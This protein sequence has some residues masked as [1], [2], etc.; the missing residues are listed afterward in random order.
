[1]QRFRIIHRTYYRFSQ[2]VIL[3]R[4]R[5]RIYP[6]ESSECRVESFSVNLDPSIK[7]RWHRDAEDNSVAVADFVITTQAL[8]IESDVIIQ[9]HNE[10]PLDFTLEEYAV[11]YPLDGSFAYTIDDGNLLAPYRVL[12]PKATY[13]QIQKWIAR[14]W[15]QG[16]PIQTYAL[17]ERLCRAIYQNFSYTIRDEPG[18]QTSLQ[19]LELN[20]G[21]CRDF[22]LLLIEAA[23]CLGFAARFVSGYLHSPPN[24]QNFGATHAWAEVYLP[25]AGWKGF[26]PTVGGLAS[27]D[28]IPVAIAAQAQ[29]VPPIEGV[30]TGDAESTMDV[31]VWVTRL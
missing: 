28:N 3:G 7:L 24:V 15:Q 20:S 30:F 19:T 9:Q 14:F 8:S 23:R 1:M 27:A 5:L 2:P 4:H 10:H 25:G 16:D 21:S 29:A 17:L 6:R 13:E 12:P 26:D 18:V 11:N 22:S 31:G